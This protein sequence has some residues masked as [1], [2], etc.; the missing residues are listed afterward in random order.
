MPDGFTSLKRVAHIILYR[1][2]EKILEYLSSC[3]D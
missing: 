1:T 3:D 2:G